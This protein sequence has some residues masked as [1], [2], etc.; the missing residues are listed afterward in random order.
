MKENERNLTEKEKNEHAQYRARVKQN[1]PKSKAFRQCICAF[2]VGGTICCIGQ[3]I[4]DMGEL[5][6]KIPESDRGSFT[7]IV[8]I[9]LG[10]LLTGFGVYDKIGAFAGAGSVVPVTG[11]ANSI[12]APAMEHKREGLVMGIGAQL[13]SLAGPVL[14]YGITSSIIVGII[15]WL[16]TLAE[17]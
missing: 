11:F 4:G 17:H 16:I 14:V 13:F 2:L 7:S 12:V 3:F 6:F 9:F 10:A 1:M 15:A 5:L 8:M